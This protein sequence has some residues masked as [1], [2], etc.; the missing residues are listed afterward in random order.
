MHC[1]LEIRALLLSRNLQVPPL[2]FPASLTVRV[3]PS[4]ADV[5]KRIGPNLSQELVR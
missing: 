3:P 4:N 5:V 1:V 2:A